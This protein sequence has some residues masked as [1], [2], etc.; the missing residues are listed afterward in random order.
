[1]F[2]KKFLCSISVNFNRTI[3]QNSVYSEDF[4]SVPITLNIHVNR[5]HKIRNLIK[6][7]EKEDNAVWSG[8]DGR[9]GMRNG[10]GP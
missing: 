3:F 9:R 8:S 2:Y 10:S 5:D 1:M 4:G 6:R 7:K